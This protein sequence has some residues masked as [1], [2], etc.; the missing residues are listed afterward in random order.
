MND[1]QASVQTISLDL[2]R[3]LVE[4]GRWGHNRWHPSI[5]PIAVIAPGQRVRADVRDGLDRQ[6]T[7]CSTDEDIL[8]MDMGRGHPLTGPFHVTGARPGDV[9]EVEIHSITDHG[10]GFTCVRPGAGLLR[11]Y[12]TEPFLAKWNLHDGYA[13]S[14]QI[15]GVRIPAD[16]FLGVVGVAP[17]AGMLR[18]YAAREAR[19]AESGGD[20]LAPSGVS[21]VPGDEWVA[22]EGLRTVPPRE[23]GGNMDAKHLRTGSKLLLPVQVEGALLS[24]GDT[25]Y[26]QGHGEV[27]SQAIEMPAT[28]EF[29]CRI[30]SAGQDKRGGRWKPTAPVILA[31]PPP[32]QPGSRVVTTG[33]PIDSSGANRQMDINVAALNA[34]LQMQDY[35]V[36]E[37]GFTPHQAYVISSVAVDLEILEIVNKPNVLVGASVDT[38]IFVGAEPGD[39][40]SA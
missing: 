36:H 30:R 16:P 34:L 29:S 8:V 11:D 40:V 20:V 24:F 14:A 33:L 23:T 26:A 7:P 37:L 5:P 19:L 17:S 25:H 35:L 22:R 18:A 12:V 38:A 21:A 13:H 15:P 27:C 9:L 2:E 4:D 32:G 31:A 39:Q 10:F 28:I 1:V 6:I 3:P